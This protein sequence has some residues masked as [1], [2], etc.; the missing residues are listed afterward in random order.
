[1]LKLQH[2]HKSMD[3]KKALIT[4]L[5]DQKQQLDEGLIPEE[6]IVLKQCSLQILTQTALIEG[7]VNLFDGDE[8]M[9]TFLE[10]GLDR[11]GEE[12]LELPPEMR[13]ANVTA[14]IHIKNVRFRSLAAPE[15]IMEMH[16][17]IVFSDQVVGLTIV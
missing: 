16:E 17:M 11:F 2:I 9:Q 4:H 1:M 7:E 6:S 12:L 14:P 10:Y 13:A 15:S 5:V 3:Y 8:E